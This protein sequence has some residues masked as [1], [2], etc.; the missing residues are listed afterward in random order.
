MVAE[1]QQCKYDINIIYLLLTPKTS[2]WTV[3]GIFIDIKKLEYVK[4]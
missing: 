3:N 1:E 2:G 4:S